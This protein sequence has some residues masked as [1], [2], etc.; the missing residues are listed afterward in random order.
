MGLGEQS[1]RTWFISFSM[2]SIT[3][4]LFRRLEEEE[5]MKLGSSWDDLLSNLIV[6][7]D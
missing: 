4:R 1:R 3:C 6:S 2:F 7:R 5:G